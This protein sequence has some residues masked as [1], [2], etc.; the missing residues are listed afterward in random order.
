MDCL[1]V[2]VIAEQVAL[3]ING[4]KFENWKVMEGVDARSPY[5]GI[6]VDI[7]YPREANFFFL[8]N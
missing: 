2:L 4:S 7:Y 8:T 3:A 1:V 5:H 6:C